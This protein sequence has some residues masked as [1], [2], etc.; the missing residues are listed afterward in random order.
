M[1]WRSAIAMLSYSLFPDVKVMFPYVP[2]IYHYLMESPLGNTK[3]NV[4][5]NG[6]AFRSQ[7]AEH[8]KGSLSR[9]GIQC[10][11]LALFSA[12]NSVERGGHDVDG[13]NHETMKN[14][15]VHQ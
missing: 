13:F 9:Y 11:P 10:G 2:I 5:F 15:G 6:Q 4:N 8:F 7:G 3:N 14:P 1:K 12:S